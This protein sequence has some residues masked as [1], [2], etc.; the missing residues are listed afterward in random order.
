VVIGAAPAKIAAHSTPDLFFGRLRVL[1][2]QPFRSH[3]LAWR[4]V[5]ALKGVILDECLLDRSQLFAVISP[6]RVVIRVP[7]AS[8]ARVMQA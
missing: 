7:W 4:A 1:S 2:Q 6:S 5:P 3:N 8:T